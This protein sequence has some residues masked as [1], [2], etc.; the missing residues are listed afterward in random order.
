MKS[1][2][3]LEKRAHY[4]LCAL[5]PDVIRQKDENVVTD[6]IKVLREKWQHILP[7]PASFDS[8]LLRWSHHW[9]RK[10]TAKKESIT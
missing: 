3:S 10:E 4:E 5:I 9:K 7:I 8:E 2:F 6:L 1:R